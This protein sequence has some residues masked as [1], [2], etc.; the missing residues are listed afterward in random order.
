MKDTE[1]RFFR[2]LIKQ[3]DYENLGTHCGLTANLEIFIDHYSETRNIPAKKLWH[4]IDKWKTIGMVDYSRDLYAGD[5]TTE[6]QF[7]GLL[8]KNQL[9]RA[10]LVFLNPTDISTFLPYAYR[11][12][13]PKR[14][15]R[16][17]AHKL[18]NVHI[19][20]AFI[21]QVNLTGFGFPIVVNNANFI[22]IYP[23]KYGTMM[24]IEPGNKYIC[25]YSDLD[26]VLRESTNVRIIDSIYDLHETKLPSIKDLCAIIEQNNFA[27]IP[28][29]IINDQKYGMVGYCLS[30]SSNV[31]LSSTGISRNLYNAYEEFGPSRYLNI[32]KCGDNILAMDADQFYDLYDEYIYEC[33]KPEIDEFVKWFITKTKCDQGFGELSEKD[34]EI[35]FNPNR[36]GVIYH[37]ENVVIASSKYTESDSPSTLGDPQ[38]EYTVEDDEMIVI[39]FKYN[40][41]VLFYT[42]GGKNI[43]H[44]TANYSF[45]TKYIAEELLRREK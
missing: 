39:G 24:G 45:L 9:I 33:H 8:D 17:I 16:E 5:V 4:Y 25:T 32:A 42:G 12:I 37:G 22:G 29:Y 44:T 28:N 1:R 14:V 34:M 31:L 21:N 3:I 36:E 26:E 23:R 2:Y 35:F 43:D 20:P 15:L 13:I 11:N 19:S 38:H 40:G 30:L 10:G 7:I 18:N 41:R 27:V 6:L